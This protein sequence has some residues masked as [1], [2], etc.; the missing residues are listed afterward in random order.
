MPQPSP[1]LTVGAR[2]YA[3]AIPAVGP[4]MQRGSTIN[5]VIGMYSSNSGRV[6]VFCETK[7]ECDALCA[8]DSLRFEA[9]PLCA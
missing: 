2:P 5:D 4:V 8:D 6:I 7:A 3:A 1:L 9:K